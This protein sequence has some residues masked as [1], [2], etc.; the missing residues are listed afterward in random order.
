MPEG[1]QLCKFNIFNR[2]S[3]LSKIKLLWHSS[4][5]ETQMLLTIHSIFYTVTFHSQ[6]SAVKILVNL[7]QSLSI[8]YPTL[9]TSSKLVMPDSDHEENYLAVHGCILHTSITIN[10]EQ[11]ESV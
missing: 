3:I 4:V 1:K 11:V 8:Y 6:I 2:K 7:L 9:P 10:L 5:E